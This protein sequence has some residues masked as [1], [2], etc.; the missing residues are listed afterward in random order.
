MNKIFLPAIIILLHTA[1]NCNSDNSDIENMIAAVSTFTQQDTIPVLIGKDRNPVI[2]I[3]ITIPG[4]MDGTKL[5]EVGINSSGTTDL[6]DVA[7]VKMYYT[8]SNAMF[9]DLVQFGIGSAPAPEMVF[10]GNQTLSKG[11]NYFWISIKPTPTADLTHKVDA[12]L[13]YII[14]DENIKIEASGESPPFR[15]RIGVALRQ[16]GQDRCHTYRI[17]GLATTNKGTLIAVYDNRYNGSFDLQADVDVGMSRSTD[18]GQTWEPMKIIMDMGEWG[19]KPEDENGIGDPSVLVDRVTGTIW[20]AAIWAHGHPGKRNW[21]A[22]RPG[23]EPAETSQLMLVRSDDDGLT[24]SDPVNLTPILKDPAW[25]LLLQGP[26]KGITMSDGTIVFPAQF[27]DHEQIPHSTIIWSRDHGENWSIGTGTKSNTTEAQV[28]ELDDGS[29]MLNMRDN[30]KGA[31]SVYTT[32]DMGLT[33]TMHSTSRS[34]LIEPVC[35]ASLIKGS[36]EINGAEQDLVLFVNPNATDGR[37]HMTIK[38]SM[39]DGMT[40]PEKYWLLLDEGRGRGYPSMTQIDEHYIGVL[41]EG[42]QSDLV[43]EKVHIDEIINR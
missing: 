27:K 10:S 26:G 12:A 41:Y 16:H 23:L 36:F 29:L 28:I 11:E 3:V 1:L 13:E 20:V 2:R 21:H 7:S 34:A 32:N 39:D 25:H 19:G 31:R 43:F 22:S 30:R 6:K 35:N 37:H 8:G 40:W 5:A 15:N 4:D 33:W 17:P 14:L 18:G 9:E 38:L 24:W 42:S